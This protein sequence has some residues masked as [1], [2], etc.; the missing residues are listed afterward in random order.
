MA[1]IITALKVQK[2]NPNRVNVYL[3]G[4]YAF[5]ISRTAAAWLR[6]NQAL[7]P[8]KIS[9]LRAQDSQEAAFQQALR[10]LSYRPRSVA[11]VRKKLVDKDFDPAVIETVINRLIEGNYLGDQAFAEEWVKNR[12]TFRPRSRRMLQFEL[13]QKG[14][15]EEHIHSALT[16][17]EDEPELAYQAG[18]RYADRLADL[19]WETFRRRLGAFLQRRGFSYGTITPLVKRI[20]DEMHSKERAS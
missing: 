6:V 9:A 10:L 4:E 19:D 15:A 1:Q 17:I 18:I 3:D 2:R 13:R 16:R 12:S 20:W 11:E 8:E 7:S 14:V 5:G